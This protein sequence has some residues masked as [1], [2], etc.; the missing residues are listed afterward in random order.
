MIIGMVGP[1]TFPR[2][3]PPPTFATCADETDEHHRVETTVF[4]LAGEDKPGLLAEVTRLLT[5]N[6]CNVRSAAVRC[7]TFIL[8]A[9]NYCS[10]GSFTCP[11]S[12]LACWGE[13]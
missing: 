6:G 7:F 1:K 4:E 5:S 3:C 2:H 11:A 12:V 8:R 9:L 13:P 10:L